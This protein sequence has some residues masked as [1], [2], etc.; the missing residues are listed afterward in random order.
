[1]VGCSE[2]FAVGVEWCRRFSL[3]DERLVFRPKADAGRISMPC[4]NC[5]PRENLRGPG[6]P[7]TARRESGDTV[8]TVLREMKGEPAEIG[9]GAVYLCQRDHAIESVPITGQ[10]KVRLVGSPSGQ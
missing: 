9:I 1:M 6:E 2:E 10:S 7:K 3:D 5:C 8:D 4:T